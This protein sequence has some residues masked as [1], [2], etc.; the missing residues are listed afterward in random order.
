MSTYGSKADGLIRL[1]ENGFLV[2][3]F[4][5]VHKDRLN[6]AAKQEGLGYEALANTLIE[7][8]TSFFN[9]HALFAVRS[10]SETEDL[11]S[12]SMAGLYKSQLDVTKQTL[13]KAL[14]ECH[15]AIK[16]TS[17]DLMKEHLALADVSKL[18]LI[19]QAMVE[20]QT[21]AAIAFTSNPDGLLD[22][23][24]LV[25]AE[26]LGLDLVEDKV[27]H[28]TYY[29]HR[30]DS[31]SYA[32]NPYGLDLLD[33]TVQSQFWTLLDQLEDSFG[34][35]LDLELALDK[36][37]QIHLLQLRP[38]TS[39]D[40]E[41]YAKPFA[42][43]D[44]S[45]IV[46]SYPGLTLPLSTS[47]YYQAYEGV[48]G[49]L[50]RRLLP[51]PSLKQKQTLDIISKQMVQSWN[52][53]AY[54]RLDHWLLLLRH[55]PF[56]KKIIPVWQ[57]MLGVKSLDAMPKKPLVGPFKRF[58]VGLN[59]LWSALMVDRIYHKLEKEVLEI[60]EDFRSLDHSNPLMLE[61]F[62]H[63]IRT[64]LL[65]HWDITLINDLVAM[66]NTGRLKKKAEK[67]GLD[68][69][70]MLSGF[71]ALESMKP[72]YS[73]AK[74]Q[75]QLH[76]LPKSLIVE[77]SQN[78]TTARL[79]LEGM[80]PLLDKESMPLIK[81]MNE[82]IKLYGD[83]SAEELKL[84]RHTQRT[85]PKLFFKSLLDST[86]R[87]DEVLKIDVDKSLRSVQK[88][89]QDAISRREVSRL[90][91]TRIYGI[92]RS[93]FRTLGERLEEEGI[94]DELED[95]FYLEMEEVFQA[96]ANEG[97]LD[98]KALIQKRK[99]A[100][101]VYESIPAYSRM[102]FSKEPVSKHRPAT[103]AFTAELDRRA[104]FYQGLG[105]SSVKAT[106]TVVVMSSA[107]DEVD[108]KGK[109][110]VCK[111]TDPGWVYL[112]LQAKGIVAEQ[113]SL[114]SH[115]AIIARELGLAAVVSIPHATKIFKTG[116]TITVDGQEGLVTRVDKEMDQ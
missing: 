7:E 61:V 60:E 38:I 11:E 104:M 90:Y 74:I 16:S 54:Y 4:I 65:A 21:H 12:Y 89:A 72:V 80:H 76:L 41:S 84:E 93:I 102:R 62:V 13:G 70:K 51:N 35:G 109:I 24:V 2:P 37:N 69:S 96:T 36:E 40:P 57:E 108:V 49:G 64:S 82:H 95:V 25:L 86:H 8:E 73:I 77:A 53:R 45:N 110:I 101:K 33:Q 56:S 52:G 85:N 98:L 91:R 71:S 47:F 23:R 5:L 79:I 43:L 42:I 59:F 3:P 39:I 31:L 44:N 18:H 22:E 66:L 105:T 20:E 26:G 97:D 67:E 58:A 116:E 83:R 106:G 15:Q 55:L 1:K 78:L 48:F 29:K 111:N 63:R 19:I 9:E 99:A 114:L 94:I 30:T 107:L 34:M 28:V 17:L 46:E 92:A 32:E 50:M 75:D 100:Y 10:S 113:G 68:A 103:T 14:L 88:R 81:L 87:A 112:L 6:E 27:P 115:T